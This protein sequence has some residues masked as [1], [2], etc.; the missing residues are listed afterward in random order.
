MAI[1]KRPWQVCSM[2]ISVSSNQLERRCEYPT[3]AVSFIH[4]SCSLTLP[5][6]S[7]LS[8]WPSNPSPRS[9][10]AHSE[11]EGTISHKPDLKRY[12]AQSS[13]TRIYEETTGNQSPRT[14]NKEN[15]DQISVPDLQQGWVRHT[16]QAAHKRNPQF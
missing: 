8:V 9:I 1:S 6:C 12:E 16:L 5:G 11:S 14:S 13:F 4:S 7:T 2:D 3:K 15:G 10:R